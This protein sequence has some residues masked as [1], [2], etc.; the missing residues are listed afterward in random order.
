VKE[1][2]KLSKASMSIQAV[3][4]RNQRRI[5]KQQTQSKL[6]VSTVVNIDQKQ[7]VKQ[8]Q[9]QLNILRAMKLA[10]QDDHRYY[11]SV[12]KAVVHFPEAAIKANAVAENPS[13]FQNPSN[14]SRPFSLASSSHLSI[15]T[16]YGQESLEDEEVLTNH[17]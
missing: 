1:Q 7:S 3:I 6:N 15:R 16:E 10:S 4:L 2:K 13:D 5:S 8:E 12:E 11:A 14:P 17:L 9:Q